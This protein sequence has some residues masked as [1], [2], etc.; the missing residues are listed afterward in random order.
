VEVAD[1][2]TFVEWRKTPP[3]AFSTLPNRLG[4]WKVY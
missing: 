4:C 2:F 1:G 3:K